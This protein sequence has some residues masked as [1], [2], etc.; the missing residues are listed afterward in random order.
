MTWMP[1]EGGVKESYCYGRT[2]EFGYH[3][4]EDRCTIHGLHATILHILG[5]DHT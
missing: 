4:V 5:L 2:D 1:A 3:A